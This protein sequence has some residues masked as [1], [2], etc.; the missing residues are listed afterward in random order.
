M[1][2]PRLELY[3]REGCH[4]CESLLAELRP[5]LDRGP[6]S[7]DLVDIDRDPALTKQYGADVPVL[8]ADGREICR[9]RLDHGAVQA[10]LNE[11]SA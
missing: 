8:V 5:Y 11:Q 4:L 9:H 7:L 6:V 1:T 2:P 3:T 10:Y